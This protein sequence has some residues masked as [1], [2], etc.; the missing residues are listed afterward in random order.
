MQTAQTTRM[1]QIEPAVKLAPPATAS[2]TTKAATLDLPTV[3]IC[4]IIILYGFGAAF[5]ILPSL[6][7]WPYSSGP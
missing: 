5:G 7:P 2:P 1:A 3:V 4:L 6:G